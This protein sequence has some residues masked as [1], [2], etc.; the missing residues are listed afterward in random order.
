MTG[1]N[2]YDNFQT[3]HSEIDSDRRNLF[4][5]MNGFHAE[6]EVLSANEATL[7]GAIDFLTEQ[8]HSH[9]ED[10]WQVLKAVNSPFQER[11]EQ[12]HGDLKKQVLG[13]KVAFQANPSAFDFL[14]FIAFLRGW[15]R[16]NILTTHLALSCLTD[17]EAVA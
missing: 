5:I 4:V 11:H 2:W 8:L 10:V 7:E 16:A 13:Y 1:F 17:S 6:A 9:L 3:G 12:T 15:L 14:G